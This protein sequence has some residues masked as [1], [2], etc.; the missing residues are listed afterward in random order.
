VY[1][2][3][4]RDHPA[5]KCFHLLFN[6]LPRFSFNSPVS[7]NPRDLQKLHK[8]NLDLGISYCFH[9]N[10][11][12]PSELEHFI[13]HPHIL[14]SFS[15]NS[16]HSHLLHRLKRLIDVFNLVITPADKTNQLVIMPTET[17]ENEMKI[18]LNDRTTY[19]LLSHD[20]FVEIETIQFTTVADAAKFYD[21][22]SIFVPKPSKRYIYFLPKVHK[23]IKDWRSIFHPKMR[24]IVSDIQSNTNQLAKHLLVQLQKIERKITTTVPSSLAVAFNITCINRSTICNNPLLATIDVES[25]YTNIP[26]DKLLSIINEQL[27]DEISNNLQRTKF[28][29]YLSIIIR[30]N[31]FQV[32]ENF[33]LQTLGFANGGKIKRNFGKHLFRCYRKV[34]TQY[35]RHPSLQ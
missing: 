16:P 35:S 23:A 29:E 13:Y 1:I 12:V 18:H 7:Y 32:G 25:L 11:P 17:V 5:V 28:M 24:P 27:M 34:C 14:P 33:Y 19:K 10:I 6:R 9:N 30:Y 15:M 4:P 22:T 31:T 2:L 26:Q 21:L 3:L 8:Q 20:E